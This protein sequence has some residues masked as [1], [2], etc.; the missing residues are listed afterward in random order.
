[1]ESA[2]TEEICSQ[3][4]TKLIGDFCHQCGQ[5]ATAI[6]TN[7]RD[8]LAALL[9]GVFSVE[10]GIFNVLKVLLFNPAILIRRY[11]RGD[12]LYF[13]SPAQIVFYTLFVTGLHLSFFDKKLLGL[14]VGLSGLSQEAMTVFSP[15]LLLI[16]LLV[17]L[18][19]LSTYLTFYKEKYSLA[20]HFIS[21]IYLFCG[22][23]IILTVTSDLLFWLSGVYFN[24]LTLLFL[25]CFFW[26]SSRVYKP[27]ANV[28][29]QLTYFCLQ[30]FIF[31]FSIG[32]LMGMLYLISPQSINVQ[33]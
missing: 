31:I 12:R 1:M 30:I 5:Q 17:P 27:R 19:M 9:S 28:L 18:L 10:R 32:F 14:N 15:Q 8:V 7:Y 16:V 33:I 11:W 22:W 25:L 6:K 2:N 13:Y 24:W 3:C 23:T 26:W 29:I 21:A 20:E 4:H